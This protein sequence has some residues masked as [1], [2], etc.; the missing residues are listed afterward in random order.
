ME[1]KGS[2]GVPCRQLQAGVPAG[3]P[4]TKNEE[5]P[6]DPIGSTNGRGVRIWNELWKS[7]APP[8]FTSK[9]PETQ[10]RRGCRRLLVRGWANF[11]RVRRPAS[12]HRQF[13]GRPSFGF[14]IIVGRVVGSGRRRRA[15]LRYPNSLES[16]LD[17]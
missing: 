3:G 12:H 2:C 4:E 7:A 5:V 14:G 9:N 6:R 1:G 17:G 11:A 16:L 13:A 15:N 8:Y 10:R